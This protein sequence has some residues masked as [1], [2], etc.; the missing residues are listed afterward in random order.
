M[1]LDKTNAQGRH[2]FF[3]ANHRA[4][5]CQNWW[6]YLEVAANFGAAADN[7]GLEDV[8]EKDVEALS[9]QRSTSATELGPGCLHQLQSENAAV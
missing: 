6:P 7:T 2:D 1:R 3:L 4:I 8:V 9:S 5:D